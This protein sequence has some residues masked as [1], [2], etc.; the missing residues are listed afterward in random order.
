MPGQEAR[1]G[2]RGHRASFD[3]REPGIVTRDLARRAY[4]CRYRVAAGEG[5]GEDV[6]ADVPRSAENEESESHAWKTAQR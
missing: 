1:D 2:F 3:D 4:E 6:C 5:K